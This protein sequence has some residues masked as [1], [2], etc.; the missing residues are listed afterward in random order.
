M[1]CSS[2][3]WGVHSNDTLGFLSFF[4]MIHKLFENINN[5]LRNESSAWTQPIQSRKQVKLFLENSGNSKIKKELN[6]ISGFHFQTIK[7]V[8]PKTFSPLMQ[9]YN[10]ISVY[11]LITAKMQKFPSK[12][13]PKMWIINSYIYPSYL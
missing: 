12:L 3:L 13:H 4:L 10:S 6:N 5:Q 2:D 7:N 1:S 8:N 9:Y 11:N